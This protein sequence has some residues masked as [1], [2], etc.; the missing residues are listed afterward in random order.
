MECGPIKDRD[1]DARQQTAARSG[2]MNLCHYLGP[3]YGFNGR[4]ALVS[5]GVNFDAGDIYA[6]PYFSPPDPYANLS[7]ESME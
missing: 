7:E 4:G 5:V 1:M 2:K 3:L 6:S